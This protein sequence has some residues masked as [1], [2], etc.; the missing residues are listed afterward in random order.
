[1]PALTPQEP[2]RISESQSL[3]GFNSLWHSFEQEPDHA[4]RMQA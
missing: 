3:T 4:L 1:M 2:Q